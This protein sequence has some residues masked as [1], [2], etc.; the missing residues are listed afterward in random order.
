M[1]KIFKWI[2]ES[3]LNI[4]LKT[5]QDANEKKSP[6]KNR[7][8]PAVIFE[9]DNNGTIIFIESVYIEHGELPLNTA[10][11]KNEAEH[12]S[13]GSKNPGTYIQNVMRNASN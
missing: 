2:R 7:G 10:Y 13:A 8:S 1:N 4:L 9:G 6:Q 3:L 11:R 12:G 5:T